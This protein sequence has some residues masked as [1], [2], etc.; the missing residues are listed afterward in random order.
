MLT[1]L[2]YSTNQHS[3]AKKDDAF[4][5]CRIDTCNFNNFKRLYLQR[6]VVKY[7]QIFFFQ[8]PVFKS[9]IQKWPEGIWLCLT[10]YC[11]VW[12]WRKKALCMGSLLVMITGM[13]CSNTHLWQFLLENFNSLMPGV[14]WNILEQICSF[15]LKVCLSMHE[16]LMETMH[17]R[18]SIMCF[19]KS[20][21]NAW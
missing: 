17:Q 3:R 8:F 7:V 20:D 16:L 9:W 13:K 14:H 1:S 18:I 19:N 12:K 11:N 21:K 15:Q 4:P 2:H 6:V 5:K 10:L